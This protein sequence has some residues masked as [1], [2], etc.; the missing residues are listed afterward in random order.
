[1]LWARTAAANTAHELFDAGERDKI[2]T[3]L[4]Q[5]ATD[6]QAHDVCDKIIE[7]AGTVP[8]RLHNF[9]EPSYTCSENKHSDDSTSR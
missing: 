6:H 2:K 7:V 5:Y 4:E 3:D 8:E 9:N 1:M